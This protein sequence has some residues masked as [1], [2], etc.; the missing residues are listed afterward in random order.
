MKEQ[1]INLYQF[2][3]LSPEAQEK[4][5]EKLWD[6]NT[7]DDWYRFMFDDFE[8]IAEILG[9][10]FK[11]HNVRLMGGSDR[12]DPNIFFRGFYSQGDGACFEGSYAYEKGSV[13]KI[14][15]YAPVD[16]E[17]HRIAQELFEIQKKNLYQIR[18]LVRHRGHYYHE[19]CTEITVENDRGEIYGTVEAEIEQ[20][21]R[22]FMKWMYRQL[23]SEY[24]HQS[25]REQVIETIR[26]N[27]YDFLKDG[28][29]RCF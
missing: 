28:R 18:A 12:S 15:E 1:I 8:Q 25:S 2:D 21:L 13:K 14:R 11:R 9:I 4:A 29:L 10:T 22:D 5:L 3:E 23:R 7:D 6:I 19:Y 24:E 16:T 26:L 17:L 27:E 20:L